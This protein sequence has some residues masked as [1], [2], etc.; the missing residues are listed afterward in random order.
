MLFRSFLR[1]KSIYAVAVLKSKSGGERMGIVPCGEGIL[2][3]LVPLPGEGQR[4]V[5]VEDLIASFLPKIFTH[6]KV[7]G[8]VLIRLVRSADIHMDE[9][10]SEMS[11][12]LAEEY[13]KSMEKLVRRRKRLQPVKLEYQG[14][15]SD[16][17]RDG[18]CRCLGLSKK[19]LFSS[20]V[21]LDLSFMGALRDMLRDKAELFY[22]RRVP[23]NSPNVEA[24]EIG[25]AHV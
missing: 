13:R 3:R 6:Y 8:T 18:L 21:P 10:S 24:L 5:L 9:A 1:N 7:D 19:H 4:Y 20:E 16:T 14:K 11:E 15:L 25:R 22:P 23:Q 2:R 17:L 12:M